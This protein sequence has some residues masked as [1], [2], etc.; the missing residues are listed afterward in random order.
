MTAPGKYGREGISVADLF[1]I[2]PDD[3]TTEQWF[4]D[5][6]W[7]NGIACPRCG[8]MSVQTGC[9]HK[10]MAFRCRG[11]TKRFSTRTGTALEASNLG[12]QTWAIAIYLVTTSLKGVSSMKL[13]RDLG[14]TQKSAWHPAHRIREAYDEHGADSPFSGPVD[15]DETFVGG[16][17][18]NKH[19]LPA[20]PP[21]R[22]H[23]R[24]GSGH[25]HEGPAHRPR[26]ST[27]HRGRRRPDDARLRPRARAPRLRALL[28]RP[29]GVSP[30]RGR[31]QALSGPARGRNLRRREHPHQRDRVVL[32]DAET[33]LCRDLPSHEP[34]ASWTATCG[35]SS[36]ATTS[37]HW[38]PPSR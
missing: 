9:A 32:V 23:V 11:C 12:L 7:P 38:T 6:R 19:E 31:V 20:P 37:G 34:E 3:D 18:H 4:R 15:V 14:I 35:S 24:Q 33:R 1:R 36:G 27:R 22:R 29:P 28:G 25:R 5:V 16:K 13:H 21:A 8:D 26:H 17:E 2:F 10:T 30:P